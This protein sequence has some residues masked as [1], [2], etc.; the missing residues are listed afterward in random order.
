M[1]DQRPNADAALSVLKDFQRRTVDYVFKRLWEDDPPAF[2]FLVADEVGLGKTLVA[3]GIVARTLEHLWDR[4][5]RLDIVYICSNASIARQNVSRLNVRGLPHAVLPT[6]LTLLPAHVRDLDKNKT[7]FISLTPGTSLNTTRSNRGG[8]IKERLVLWQMLKR[9]CHP[10]GKAALTWTRPAKAV[11]PSMSTVR[12]IQPMPMM[13]PSLN[14]DGL[15]RLLQCSV[16][17]RRYREHMRWNLPTVDTALTD[18]F[19]KRLLDNRNLYDKL[20]SL[21][22][23]FARGWARGQYWMVGQLRSM[24]ATVC[25][26]AL[27]PDL[28]ILDEFQ[29]FRD[30]LDSSSPA[31]RLTRQILDFQYGLDSPEAGLRA[32]VLL[33]SATPYKM[34]TLYGDDGEDHHSDF[35]RTCAFLCEDDEE[36]M[37]GLR[38]AIRR[39]RLGLLDGQGHVQDLDEARRDLEARLLRL[40][41]RTERVRATAEGDA[42]LAGCKSTPSLEPEDLMQARVIDRVAASVKAHDPIEYWKSAP[43]LLNVMRGYRLKDRFMALR[44]APPADLVAAVRDSEAWLLKQEACRAI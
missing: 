30:L 25:V 41:V 22:E 39:Y 38:A 3:R 43:Y 2:R 42:M 20:V 16:S 29:R 34:L 13:V 36:V 19:L 1:S 37:R 33:L 12:P 35:L 7:N 10:R 24:L 26:K 21:C 8:I 23:D 27:Q 44:H 4:V 14:R 17:D 31:A 5:E 32:R 11:A 6:R 18:A 40:M 15:Y 9:L 28:I